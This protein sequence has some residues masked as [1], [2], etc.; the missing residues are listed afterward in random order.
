MAV[1]MLIAFGFLRL[2][3]PPIRLLVVAF[4]QCGVFVAI[5]VMGW[6]LTLVIMIWMAGVAPRL[7]SPP[8]RLPH[9]EPFI[10]LDLTGSQE[11][12]KVGAPEVGQPERPPE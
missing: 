3:H 12:Q 10:L 4:G 8:L 9:H 5:L 1:S 11:E 6:F 7:I 2:V